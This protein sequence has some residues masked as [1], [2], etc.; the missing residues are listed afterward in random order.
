MVQS[1][2]KD[3]DTLKLILAGSEIIKER[4]LSEAVESACKLNVPLARALIMLGHAK[5]DNLKLPMEAE[6]LVQSG[7]VSVDLAIKAL[8]LAWQ[9]N[10]ALPEAIHVIKSVHKKTN[11]SQA[12]TNPMSELM[13]SAA[14]ISREQLGRAVLRSQ[15]TKLTLGRVLIVN[16]EI[17][18]SLLA[19]V[20]NAQLLIRDCK[21]SKD[22]A[23]NALKTTKE[24][25]VTI[26]QTLFELAI[27][28]EQPG[29]PMRLAELFVMSGHIS[30]GDMLESLE[31]ELTK[32]K[33]FGQI[34]LEQGFVTTSHLETAIVLQDMVT[35]NC[36][37]PHHAA[38]ALKQ[39]C[40][41][42]ISVYQ[43]IAELKPPP[44]MQ[45][46]TLRIGDLLALSEIVKREAI[47]RVLAQ[48][49]NST[50]KI[51]TLLLNANLISEFSLYNALRCL[52]L[53]RQGYLSNEQAVAAL[54]YCEQHKLT[55]DEAL[56]RISL[57]PPTR[58]QWV[59]A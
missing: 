20:I 25:R 54:K 1:T 8:R 21:I 44:Q 10:I 13:L 4:E 46:P 2:G 15:E 9:N 53:L 58:M 51:G 35:N 47:E 32:E 22:Q 34:L 27:Y 59:W 30:E 41:K 5:G 7:K 11:L 31:I 37:K 52:S 19:A 50:V 38:E 23:I 33:E 3:V 26:E 18:N 28:T 17:S 39:T 43:A 29:Q 48:K 56:S 6:Q 55:P 36:I 42:N 16:R 24:R 45:Q 40:A 49:G 14:I 57:F 12:V